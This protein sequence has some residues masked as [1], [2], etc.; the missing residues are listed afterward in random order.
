MD[1][2]EQRTRID[3]A[4]LAL[5]LDELAQD[6]T[7]NLARRAAS[8]PVAAPAAQA[9]HE[10]QVAAPQAA[11]DAQFAERFETALLERDAQIIELQQAVMELATQLDQARADDHAGEMAALEQRLASLESRLVEQDR[12]IRHT[13]SMLIEWIE[14]DEATRAAA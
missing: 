3:A 8:Q 9:A 5:V 14:G 11:F 7:L 4:M 6:G 12:T 13:L 10:S 2:V 1:A